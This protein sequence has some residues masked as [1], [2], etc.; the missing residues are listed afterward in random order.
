[1]LV[2]LLPLRCRFRKDDSAA[3]LPRSDRAVKSLYSR[4][5]VVRV[6]EI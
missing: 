1:M 5:S 4:F 6:V 3:K 2:I